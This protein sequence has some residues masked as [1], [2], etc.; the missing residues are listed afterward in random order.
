MSIEESPELTIDELTERQERLAEAVLLLADVLEKASEQ[1]GFTGAGAQ[2]V[3]TTILAILD[4]EGETQ[5][6]T[7]PAPPPEDPREEEPED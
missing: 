2:H 4:G 3:R 5:T 1:V 7:D 6:P